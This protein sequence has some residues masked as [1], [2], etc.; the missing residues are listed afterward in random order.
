MSLDI[1]DPNY[2]W[3][4]AASQEGVDYGAVQK[5]FMDQSYGIVANKAKILF[6]DPFRLG[7]EIVHRN[8][9]ATK[10]V[11]IYAFRVN[12]KL[13]Y[14][15]VFFIN[16]EI[17]AADMLYRADVKRFVPLSEDW[18]AWLV[19]GSHERAGELADRNRVRQPDA[20]MDRLAYPQRVKYAAY[21]DADGALDL[22]KLA[23]AAA[24]LLEQARRE[25]PD[26]PKGWL[27]QKAQD[28]PDLAADVAE[29]LQ[30][31]PT[32]A[33][34]PGVMRGL[35]M[36]LAG[37]LA[38][39][40]LAGVPLAAG[41]EALN[42][43]H[44]NK[45]PPAILKILQRGLVFGS[46]GLGGYAA[47]KLDGQMDPSKWDAAGNKISAEENDETMEQA[48]AAFTK[49]ASDGSLWKDLLL[50]S[51]DNTPLRKL[52]PLVIDEH[53]PEAL[54][55][56]ANIIGDNAVAAKF[57]VENYTKEELETANGWMAKEAAANQPAI[58]MIMSPALAKSAAQ[59]KAV[60]DK[61]YALVDHRPGESINAVVEELDGSSIKDLS[62][63][64]RAN[65]ILG[66]GR[67]IEAL[68]LREDYDMLSEGASPLNSLS[69]SVGKPEWVYF[70]ADKQL[71]RV[72]REV[73]GDTTAD[74]DIK[75]GAVTA[76]ELATDKCYVALDSGR[77]HISRP[78]YVIDKAHDGECITINVAQRWGD[79]DT[80]FYAPGREE[81]H[82][83]YVSDSTLFLEIKCDVERRDPTSGWKDSGI[84]SVRP[85]CDKVLM[86][87]RGIDKW[88][89]TSGGFTTS[90]DVTVKSNHKGVSFDIEHREGGTILKSAR[91]LGWLEAHLKLAEDFSITTDKAGDMLEK[92]VDGDV[93]YRIYDTVTKRAYLTRPNGMEQ[94]IQ[95]YDPQL[96][97]ALDAPQTQVLSTTTPERSRQQSR[98]GDTYQGLR[99]VNPISAEDVLPMADIMQRAPEEL[100]Q[101]SEAYD[102]PHIFDH[103]CV[104]QM[105]KNNYSIVEQIKQYIPD[106]EAG[107]DRCFRVL[108]LLRYRPS[109]FEEIYGKDDLIDFEKELAEL[110]ARSGENLLRMLRQFDPDQYAAQEN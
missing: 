60:F 94:W 13:L 98:Y 59:Q 37:G 41:A 23:S 108:F 77:M 66:D 61:G 100:A 109:D 107:V 1:I 29:A 30:A 28:E 42:E 103:A 49:S 48:K 9:K 55:K 10:M 84:S 20:Y 74:Q 17:K 40:F 110:A 32:K 39:G 95:S 51:A 14:A 86:T 3:K 106:L 43:Q 54:E 69:P 21:T 47:Q 104:G 57:L 88:M 93:S 92:A 68:L 12:G 72:D 35:G 102:L 16:G 96:Q 5:S 52:L 67:M 56:L 62:A 75:A 53:G 78:F 50:H 70:P 45:L 24:L 46:A 4:A 8:E 79:K 85:T 18:C 73:F 105:S 87:S 38:G 11:G 44:G 90:K 26:D 34:G 101:M 89:R 27:A 15:P 65:V 33:N 91:D 36:G 2:N 83:A 71:L 6:Q 76:G 64:G 80:I 19:R 58:E 22:T 82:G 81:S 97:V 99:G 25:S 31:V 63:P 7:F